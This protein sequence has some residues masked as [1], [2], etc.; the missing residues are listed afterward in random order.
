M[1]NTNFTKYIGLTQ[2]FSED[3]FFVDFDY[4]NTRTAHTLSRLQA[5]NW[6]DIFTRSFIFQWNLYNTWVD[7]Y[8]I[9]SVSVEDIGSGIL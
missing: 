1:R 7:A 8:F 6:T 5:N 9:F 3:T 2:D 4:N